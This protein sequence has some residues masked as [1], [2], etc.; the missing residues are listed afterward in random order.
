MKLDK[1]CKDGDINQYKSIMDE[2]PN[3]KKFDV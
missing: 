1:N 2:N 3:L